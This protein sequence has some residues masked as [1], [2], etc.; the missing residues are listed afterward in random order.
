MGKDNGFV[1]TYGFVFLGLRQL[2]AGH[3]NERVI[4]VCVGGIRVSASLKKRSLERSIREIS[5]L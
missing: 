3:I 5:H 1:G 4:R 2:G